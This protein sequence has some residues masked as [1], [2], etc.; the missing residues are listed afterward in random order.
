MIRF[1]LILIGTV[2]VLNV[3][4]AANENVTIEQIYDMAQSVLNSTEKWQEDLKNYSVEGRKSKFFPF[5]LLPFHAL[6]EYFFFKNIKKNCC[7]IDF[8]F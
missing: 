8:F 5:G 6:C 3:V 2:G 1:T 7:P 4:S